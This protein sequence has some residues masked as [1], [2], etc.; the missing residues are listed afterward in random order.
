MSDQREPGDLEAEWEGLP[1]AP[2][3]VPR[4]KTAQITLRLP[5][6]L[7]AQIKLIANAR[8]VPYHT[9]A[10]SWLIEGLQRTDPPAPEESPQPQDEQLNVKLE[11]TVLDQIKAR[12]D[13][14]RRPYHRLAREW[15]QEGLAREQQRM[16]SDPQ[17]DGEIAAESTVRA[18]S[19]YATGGGGVTFERRVAA[20]YLALM[21]TGNTSPELGDGRLIT[22]IAFQQAPDSP[23]DDLVLHAQRPDEHAPSLQLAVGVRRSPKLVP[24]DEDTQ[25]L[26]GA[27]V[28]ALLADREDGVEHR[29]ALVDAGTRPDARELAELTGWAAKQKDAEGFFS[30][31]QTPGKV[32]KAVSERLAHVTK[33]VERALVSL[34]V[35][36]PDTTLVQQ[37]TWELLCNLSVITP[38]VEDPD[39]TDWIEAQNRLLGV[40]RGKNLLAAGSLLDRLEVLAGQFAPAAATVDL[41]LLRRA[42]HTL[43][44][45]GAGRNEPG[46]RALTDLQRQALQVR[47]HLGIGAPTSAFQLDRTAQ[48]EHIIKAAADVP[49]LVVHGESGV[50]KSAAVLNAATAAAAASDELEVLCLNLRHL[51]TTSAELL[52]AV[53]APLETLFSEFTAPRRVLVIDGADA[54]TETRRDMFTYLVT[55]ARAASVTV[56]AVAASE[57]QR[58]VLDLLQARLDGQVT[59]LHLPGLNDE[60]LAE[61]VGAFPE[62]ARLVANA[63]SR[64][65]L[66][67]LVVVD[68]LVRSGLSGIPLSD[69]DAMREV[70]SGLIRRHESS[71]RGTPEARERVLLALAAHQLAGGAAKDLL[72]TLDAGAVDG[73]R[74]DGL[75]RAASA[76]PW[77]VL[78]EFAHDELRRFAVARTLLVDRD[79]TGELLRVSAPRWALSSATL[80]AQAL[81]SE[82]DP[83]DPPSDSRLAALQSAFDALVSAGH[84]ARWADVPV[85]ALLSLGDPAPLLRDAW[86]ELTGGDADGLKRVLRLLAQ[87]HRAE[88]IV[89][90]D[91]AEPVVALLLAEQ[92]PWRRGDEVARA[93]REWLLALVVREAPE[94]H[95]LRVRLREQIVD[96][97]AAADKRERAGAEAAAKALEERTPEQIQCD[98]QQT[99]RNKSLFAEI[100]FPRSKRRRRRDVP[101]ELTD[102]TV[103][104]LL[105]LLGRDLGEGGERLLRRVAHDAPWELDPVL[106]EPAA[107]RAL[108]GYGRGLLAELTEAYYI[109]EEEDQFG[110][111]LLDDGVRHHRGRLPVAPLAAWYRGPFMALLQNDFR[112]AIAVLNR[113]L[114]HGARERVRHL[115]S[116]HDRWNRWNRPSDEEIDS[117]SAQLSITGEPRSY[118]GDGHVWLWYRGTGVGPYPCMSALQACELICE[119]LIEAQAPIDRLVNMLLEGCENLAMVGLVVGLLIRHVEQAGSTIDPYLIEPVIWELEFSRHASESSRL[120]GNQEGVAHP[121]RRTW[122]LREAATLLVLN[123]DEEGAARLRTLGEQLVGNAERMEREYQRQQPPQSDPDP[124]SPDEG[125]SYTTRV[126]NWASALDRE[127]YRIYTEEGQTLIGSTPPEDVEKALQPSNQDLARGNETI[128]LVNRYYIQQKRDP[129][130]APPGRD[131]LE[132]DLDTA[133]DLL[134]Q[135]P[136]IGA[137]SVEDAT[138]LVAAFAL[139]A[140]LL[141]GVQIPG[142]ALA[143]VIRTLL[144]IAAKTTP[145]DELEY[146]GSYFEQ[147]A[148]RTAAGA[149]PLLLLPQAAALPGAQ[150]DG[151]DES[152]AMQAARRLAQA[153]AIETRLHLARALDALWEAPCADTPCHHRLALDLALEAM[154][155]CILGDWDAHGQRRRIERLPRALPQALTQIKDDDL[156]V[157]RLDPAIRALGAAAVSN[158]CVQREAHDLLLDILGAQRRGLLA[159]DGDLDQ[160]GTHSLIAARSLWLLAATGERGPLLEHCETYADNG[161]LLATMLRALAA[162]AEETPAAADAAKLIWP[163][164]IEAILERHAR[165]SDPFNDRHYGDYALAALAPNATYET[166][167]LYREVQTKPIEWVD[168]IAWQHAIERWLPLA[169]GNPRCVDS[170]IGLIHKLPLDKQASTGLRW[171]RT[172][173]LDHVEHVVARSFALNSWLIE[174][175]SAAE[176]AGTLSDW[177]ELVDALVVAGATELAPYS[178]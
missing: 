96:S 20:R 89:D 154:R 2:A 166:E 12:A 38:R 51:P 169:A 32:K 141:E 100:G 18:A 171:V 129:A 95:P 81:L 27:Y 14:L 104:E 97:C 133:K 19:P 65:L 64:E 143:F 152:T 77:E 123:A 91:I 148:D 11:Q 36:E 149:L 98:E 126:R 142:E 15:V 164:I 132:A 110:S 73:L 125:V 61:I 116:L 174:T 157:E 7:L 45:P 80:V 87:R 34:S 5:A 88:A 105:A 114:N 67:R 84:G 147:G 90:P 52:S 145:S 44:E 35:S 76:N 74:H 54:A 75:L 58:V 153:V 176:H 160:R 103:L 59:D 9:L 102:E 30:L 151:R 69:V 78:P 1:E 136:V 55:A 131:E 138:T 29:L 167:Y 168:P 53:G 127:R 92:T 122:T 111:G 57:S 119:R 163:E 170:L 10:R 8:S 86:P 150:A 134:E 106:E 47:D 3:L 71:E 43:L 99:K 140:H 60:E 93:L 63:R 79:P 117:A 37:R 112:G 124:S 41:P 101:R 40:A 21:L 135:P 49:G 28:K 17:Q 16:T 72:L 137:F 139:H 115:A 130:W 118:V 108:A 82:Y 162:A 46:W 62:L 94:G 144:D 172:L 159:H 107:P 4:G 85:E 120:A 23:V 50:G 83:D 33:M 177:Q 175:R 6:N 155:D 158:A 22:S 128:R 121:E 48:G 42:V 113:L 173:A 24:S 68:L 31:M 165:G 39:T 146:S 156:L 109:D 13:Q 178:E 70:W 26:L 161:N 66:R 25:K 56:I